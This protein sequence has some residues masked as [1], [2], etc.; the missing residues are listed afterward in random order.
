MKTR[1]VALAAA[2]T[3]LS[4]ALVAVATPAQAA[5]WH[6]GW[7]LEDEG[8]AVVVDYGGINVDDLPA[9]GW[10]V[11]CLIGGHIDAGTRP[12]Y[13]A[14][15]EAVGHTVAL[16]G[17][18]VE[19][20]NDVHE[21]DHG[22]SWWMFSG[23]TIPGSWSG[24]DYQIVDDGPNVNVAVGA[25]YVIDF[26]EDD[27]PRPAPAFSE[28]EAPDPGTTAPPEPDTSGTIVTLPSSTA[29]ATGTPSPSGA[30]TV[31]TLTAPRP[32]VKGV[33]RLGRTLRA[34]SRGWS[35][36]G[37]TKSHQWLRNGKVIPRAVKPTYTLT[38]KDVGKRISVRVTGSKAPHAPTTVTSPR[39]R[40]VRR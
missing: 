5:T 21:F 16:N 18:Y 29:P 2:G 15:M 7:C 22:T 33:P 32:Q 28:P 12:T 39:S 10:D 26:S 34:R 17:T 4:T 8:L 20:V 35:P 30:T 9:E 25:R 1:G 11:R 3:L 14:A 37:V 23:A 36:R 31:G 19:G 40:K 24:N 13:V 38:R 27:T 6:Q